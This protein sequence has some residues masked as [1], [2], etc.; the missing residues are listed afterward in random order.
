MSELGV[1]LRTLESY[2]PVTKEWRQLARMATP[3]AYVGVAVL[4][5]C[6]YAVG[7]WN[8]TRRALRTVER[9]SIEE[10]RTFFSEILK[11]WEWGSSNRSQTTGLCATIGIGNGWNW[12]HNGCVPGFVNRAVYLLLSIGYILLRFEF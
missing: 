3:R 11:A 12:E 10:V 2:N 8:E 9:Y 6:I 1:E 4:D 5:D 7:G